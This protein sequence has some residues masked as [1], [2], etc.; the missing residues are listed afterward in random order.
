MYLYLNGKILPETEASLS[1]NDHGF[2]FGAGFFETF[3]TFNGRPHLLEEHLGRL[4]AGCEQ[5]QIRLPDSSIAEA[6]H[7]E[8]VLA[9]LLERNGLPDAVF[10]YTVAAGPAPGGL[11]R[12]PY[13][14]PTELLVPRPV[15][16]LSEKPIS[17]HILRTRRNTEEF[18][19]RPK[20]LAYLNSLAGHLELREREIPPGDEG[21]MLSPGAHLSEGVTGNLFFILDDRLCTP[22]PST[23]LLSGVTRQAVLALAEQFGIRIREDRFTLDDLTGADAIFITNSVRGLS[24][25][26]KVI[27]EDDRLLWTGE[28]E[29][30]PVFTKLYQVYR[31]SLPS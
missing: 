12:A 18:E 9:E 22:D 25:A 19:P 14:D 1:V 24:P 21:V 29:R 8:P 17:L 5:I 6:E 28:S 27:S 23:G 30:H 16:E 31:D 2:L 7:M 11:P 4:K 26:A 3:R 10:R 15:P 13:T 20:G